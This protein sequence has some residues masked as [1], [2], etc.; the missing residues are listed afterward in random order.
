MRVADLAK[1]E[2]TAIRPQTAGLVKR[3]RNRRAGLTLV[4]VMLLMSIAGIVLA[5]GVPA[6]VR[7]LGR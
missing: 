4:E 3:R 6:F 7:P 2:P 1:V 5:V